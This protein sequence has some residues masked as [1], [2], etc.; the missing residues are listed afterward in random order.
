MATTTTSGTITSFGNTPQ[1]TDDLFLASTT[2]LTED[3]TNIVYIDVMAN[4]L[5]GNAKVLYSLDDGISSGGTRPADLL[6]QDT[7]RAESVS[8]DTSL[9]GAKIWITS[10][11]KVGYD[12]NTLSATFKDQL[13]HLNAGQYMTDSFTYAIRLGNGTL[14][15]ATATVQIAGV[16]D[17]PVV[18]G[19]VKGAA[20][21]DGSK[22]TMNALANASDVDTGTVLHVVNVPATLPAGVT[23]DAANH[24][25]TL[26]PS[27]AA[28]QH[29]A[30][31]QTTTVTISYGVS[32]GVATTAASV[33][34]TITGSNDAPV[35]TSA[36][37]GAAVED[38]AKVTLNALANASDVDDGAVLTVVN[39]PS[40]LPAGVAYDA[41]THSFTLDPA[42]A[43]YQ[44]L[45][46]GQT[47]TVT[48]NYGVSDGSATTGASVS[49]TITGNNDAPAVTGAVTGAAVEDGAKVTLNALANANDV[50]DGAVLSVVNVP[51]GLPSGVSYDA[52]TH[53]FTLDPTDAAYQHLAEG[54]IT[55]VTVNYGVSDGTDTTAASVSFT[56]TGTNDA[57]VV[58]GAVTGSAVEDGAKVTL[59]ALANVSDVDDGAVL[60][61]VNVPASLPGGVSY[62][63]GTHSFTLDPTNAAYQSLAA[64]QTTTVTVNYGVS[65]GIATTAASV[66]YTVTGTN[67]APVVTNTS[68]ATAGNVQEDIVTTASGQLSASDVDTGATQAWSVHGSDAGTYGSIAV[69]AGGQW[70][71]TLNN[72]AANVQALAAGES[73]DETFTIRVTDDQGAYVDQTITVT[74]NGTNDA[75]VVTGAVTSG[76]VEDG[77]TVTLNAL[78]HAS[79]VDNG[80]TLAVANVPATLPAGV[81]YDAGTQSFTLDPSDAAYQHLAQGQTTVVS[82]NYG[83]TDGIAT[84]AASVSFTVT[85]TNDAPVVTGAVAGTATEDGATATVNALANASDVD[86]STVLAVTNVPVAL[87]AGV[88]YDAVAQ[89]FTLDPSDT[90][91]QHLAQGQ[92]TVVTVNY[93][94]TDGIATTA[95]SVSFTVTGTNDAPVVTGAVTGTATEDGAT[96]TVN[97][98]AN[99][100]DV[101]DS[102][103]L[104]VTDVPVALPAGVTYDAVAQTF[105]LDPSD[106]AYQHLAQG[107]T[108]VV[109]VNYGVTDGIATTAASVSFTVTGTNDAPVVTGAV[110]GNATEDGSTVTLNALANASDVDD[111]TTLSVVNVPASLPAGVSYDAATHSFALNP[112]DAAYQALAQGETTTVTVNYGVTDGIATTPAS[113]SFTL[114]GTNDTPVVTNAAADTTG[115]VQEDV[116]TAISG[117]L[118]ASDVDHGATQTWSVQGGDTGTYGSIAVDANGKWTYTLNNDASN[119]QSLAAGE[120]HD[121]TFTV[122]V[123]D[124]QGAY[125]DQTVTVTVRG[126]N[127]APIVTGAV[128]GS[129]TED[130][131]TVTLDALANA[132]D[133]DH[134]TT[135]TVVD[136]PASL[137]AG[138][139]YDATSHSFTLDPSDNAYQHLAQGQTTTVTINYSVSDSITTTPAV[140]SFT[141][142]GTNDAPVVTGAVTGTATEDGATATVN[143]LANASDVDDN[144]VLAVTNVPATLPA[145]VTYDAVAQ[146]FTLDP[147]DTAYQHLAQGQTTVVTVNYGVT[148]GIATTAASVSFTVT[149]TNDAPVVTG[150]VIGTATEDGATATVNALAN[151][152]DVDDN[153]VLAITNVPVTLPAGVTYDAGTQSFTL[154][155]SDAAYQHLAQGQTT[156]VTVNYGVTD[157]IATTAASVS[158]TVTGTNDAPVVTGAVTGTATEDG[159]TATVN[160]LANASD[161]DDSTVLAVTDVPVTLPAGVTY[162]A[163]AQTFTLDPTGTAY[164]H[165]AQGQTTVVTVNYGVT[166]GI[167]TT[168]ASVSFTV[169]GTNDAPVVT[170]AVTGNATE[171]SSTVTLNALANASDVDDSTTLSV[172]NIATLPAGVTFDA[173]THNFTLDPSDAAYQH[174]AQ[175]QTTTV[176]VS[177]EVSDGITTTPASVSFTVTG[178]NDAPIAQAKSDAAT[179]GG[180]IVQG[181]VTATDVDDNA[182]LSYSLTATAPAGL[183]FN[184]DGSY[185]FDPTVGAYDHLKAGATQ[186]VV[187]NYQ[188]SD[189]IATGTSSLTITVTGTND[190]PVVTGAVTG[191][192][193]EDGATATVNALANASDVDDSTVLAVT[194]IPVTLP[195]GVTYDAVA[196]TFTLDPSDAAYQHLAQGQTTVI[197]VNYGVTDGIATTAAS[198]SFTVTG[199]NDAPVVTG[200]VTGTATEDGSK[201]TLN[202]LA[203]ASDVDDGTTLSVVNVPVSLPTGVAYDAATHSFTLDPTNAAFQSLAAGQTT[204]VTVNYGVSDGIA[205]TAASVSWT[206]TGTNDA[207]VITSGATAS[208][209]ENVS[210]STAVYTVTATDIDGPSL[211]YSLSGTDASLFNINSA[212][213]AVTFKTSPN[214]EAPADAGGNNVYDIIVH[215][216]DGIADTAQAV[217]ISVTNVIE[218]PTTTISNIHISSDTGSSSSDFITKTAAQTITAT[219]SAPLGAGESVLGSVD[220]GATWSA[221]TSVS[222]TSVSWNTTLSGSSAIEFKVVNTDAQS[223]PVAVQS[224]V[225]DTTIATPTVSLTNDTGS[226][227]ND[228]I[229][230]DGSLTVSAT[231]G[232]VT[233]TYTVDGGT[234]S[235]SYVA[236]TADGNHTVVVT[237][238]D[239]AGNVA[240]A[241]I[242]F[243]LDNSIATPTISGFSTDSATLGDHITNDTTLVITGTAEAGSSVTVKD[244]TTVLGTVTA[245]GS[246]AW[247]FGPS[248][249][250]AD[251]AHG[252]TAVSTDAAGNSATSAA[253]AVTVD[254]AAPSAPSIN[255]IANDSGTVG[256]H[257]TNDTTL[258]VSGT[259]EAN[260]TI[261]VFRDG[262]SIGTAT[263][264]SSG[265]WSLADATT[266]SNGTTYQYS[267]KATDAAGNTSG[268]STNYAVTIDTTVFAPASL[269]L[270]A[271][272][273]TGSSNSDNITKNTSGLTISGSGENGATVT[274]F[275]DTNGNGI[276][277]GNEATLGTGTVSNGSFSIDIALAAGT[278]HVVA[279][280][281]DLAGN[282]SSTSAALDITVDT[283][284]PNTP[285]IS[286]I[287]DNV[288]PVT[289][290][291]GS[292]GSSNDATPTLSGTAEAN[293]TVT[294]KDGTTTLG[295]TTADANGNWTY[296]SATLSDGSHSFT[297][298]AT[299]TAGNVSAASTAYTETI[300]T[301]A[302]GTPVISS[303]NDNVSP[304]TGTVSS[305]GSSNDTTPTLSGTAEASSTVTVK[306][307]TSTLG[308]TTA[309]AS[310]NWTFTPSALSQGSHSFTVTATDAAGNVSAASTAYTETIDTTVPTVGSVAISSATGVQNNFL[311]AGDVV[312]ITVAMSESVVVTGTPQLAL[313]IGGT[314]VQA[315]YASGSGSSSLVFTYTI[316][317]NQTDT[318]GIS[319]NANGLSLNGGAIN[320]AAGNLATLTYSAVADNASYKVDT[321]APSTPSSLSYNTS[322][323]TLTGTADVG[324]TVNVTVAGTSE[325]SVTVGAGGTFSLVLSPSW[326]GNKDI[327]VTAADSAGNV[328]G[329]ASINNTKYPAGIAGEA[330][331]LALMDPTPDV[332][333]TISY[334]VNGMP[335]GWTLSMGVNNGDGSW[336]MQTSDPSAIT[337]TTPADYVGALVLTVTYNWTNADGTTGSVVVSDNVE[338]YAPGSPIF[339][340]SGD[341]TLTGSSGSDLFVF[342]Q[343]ITNDVLH[344]FDLAADKI[345]LIGF[346][347]SSFSDVQIANDSAGNAVITLASGETITVLGVDAGALTVGNFVFDQ[348]PVITNAGTMT[349]NDGAML[350]IGGIIDNTGTIVLGSTND[351]TELE[352][353]VKSATLEGGGQLVMSDNANNI[354]YGGTSDAALIN[355]DNT[356][357]GAGQIGQGQMLLVNEGTILA[358]GS[359]ALVIDTGSHA[360]SNTGT[361]EATGSGGLI[362]SGD[363]SNN[364]LL[365]AN[366]GNIMVGGNVSGTGTALIGGTATIEFGSASSEDTTFADVGNGTLKLDQST[367]YTGTVSGFNEGDRLDFA[368]ILSGPG[369][370][371]NFA[372]N[373]AG[374]G[375]TLTLSDG[376]H[377]AAIRL[378]GQYSV[379][380]F[381]ISADS[382]AGTIV[383]YLPVNHSEPTV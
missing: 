367:A 281:T 85:G 307:G 45:A 19:A 234:P 250:L 214:Y 224:Y 51:A 130:Q 315:N 179:E 20:V 198:V 211:T 180:A 104:A 350:P 87:P 75:P 354:I 229:T 280:Q 142:T 255:A 335:T 4:D 251:G 56:V 258:T 150:A 344:N 347:I 289:G 245:D 55:T 259:A 327:V 240:T 187:V 151:A 13:Q 46:A 324:S 204:T 308:T 298:T 285:V 5:G 77:S 352:I 333:D 61:V 127:D 21:E 178:T 156:V 122:R 123:T 98:L 33:S 107:Q 301:T 370:T 65:D 345:D 103:V 271:A 339:A 10:D 1:A 293:S 111:S 220:G 182:S 95:A 194:N 363:L 68:A 97:A 304:V 236:P 64:G 136:V 164:Q 337:V 17:A 133:V 118:S 99:A 131:S 237:D 235:G 192:A 82:V 112:S 177:Y 173:N 323:H 18:T 138:V 162:D 358:N 105:T 121:E 276:Q 203:N 81:T 243:K 300:D 342:A 37:T 272:D 184:S 176:T 219:L 369:T 175:G 284:V 349:V 317:S 338:A 303:I 282:V 312:S 47:T 88:T 16:N 170:G 89:T 34:F 72:G 249:S 108:T 215:A 210:T 221:V 28:Y 71:Y 43:A 373:A 321:T 11:G 239:T 225:L 196:Q 209:P 295:T 119:V 114:T 309:D 318:N 146:T 216:N 294:V 39:V 149:G 53:S 378:Q 361:L 248:T 296:T 343:P 31:G 314:T 171:D 376:T 262:I 273:D 328:S 357:S 191:S 306:D 8:A 269:D 29:L 128:T 340:W 110:T 73:H 27:N 288:S 148:D 25:F 217:A 230:K 50:D 12:S 94:V 242:T 263:A 246:G 165:L 299:D 6:T 36:V 377:T 360:V 256:D 44:H 366:D 336:T 382:G 287:N 212:T 40:S 186:D 364:G 326:S 86:D 174:L 286:S 252:F 274:L 83:V 48:V 305:G 139:S 313:N 157:G 74:V 199:T 115:S 109:T 380:G 129:A 181:N 310:G 66:S 9:N 257:I 371:I 90:A 160:A 193:T 226:S 101:D 124:D 265:A 23:Y 247:S 163:V 297:V 38:G 3:S 232:D 267:A 228:L 147:S 144:T 368:D 374:T 15:W 292:G 320:D 231:A 166:D 183:V 322:T 63:A 201:A 218:T 134:G 2:G 161:V 206:V 30:A 102:T 355:V 67:D 346:G 379:D 362:I 254:T 341:D 227:N 348:D 153:T 302:P 141:I 202:A 189:G 92:T 334:T 238:T 7:G 381:H 359:N 325:G 154:D 58:S 277:N 372:E 260:S 291:V 140:V 135:L 22:V 197:T 233:R 283:T 24:A 329:Q 268:A 279:F 195:A 207:P 143:A 35:V 332:A 356:I 80:T 205:T 330:I 26:D 253:F 132:S 316:Q 126:T 167:A 185:S 190:A 200:A 57:P 137:P 213:G 113:V 270:A 266:L 383:S 278:H 93:G 14:S 125:V 261:T 375:G 159:A 100:S 168:A 32:D 241:S 172:T 208:T 117:Q 155:P 319:L 222:G 311:N 76:A 54:A 169:T 60:S 264:N 365:W 52:A 331:N 145:G 120:S 290:T 42:N 59:N 41:A 69:D 79:D 353:L 96:A 62:D 223:G 188:V 70:T 158:F 351:S 244:G 116:V 91:Y 106:T 152:S 275:D 84:T 78:A 49:F